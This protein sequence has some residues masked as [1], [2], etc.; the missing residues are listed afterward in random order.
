MGINVKE[1]TCLGCT[2]QLLSFI[3]C[4]LSFSVTSA[5]DM[6]GR[7]ERAS[8]S[9]PTSS[10]SR[11]QFETALVS[12]SAR[13]RDGLTSWKI[14]LVGEHEQEAV[15]HLSVGEDPLELGPGLVDSL[16]V[17]RVNHKDESLQI[18]RSDEGAAVWFSHEILVKDTGE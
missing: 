9:A 18:A 5:G 8:L 16:T 15:P 13:W 7:G 12:S 2:Y 10:A 3:L 1:E 11:D 6:A 17:P 14:L 4:R